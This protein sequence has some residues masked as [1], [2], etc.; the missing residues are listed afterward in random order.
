MRQIRLLH[1]FLTV[2]FWTFASRLLGFIRDVIIAAYLG[3]G[4]VAEAFLV[5]F[6]L[7]NMFRRIF[8]EGAFNT[9]FVPIFAKKI[10]AGEDAKGFA[11]DAFS[12]LASILI[13][14]TMIAHVAMPW[15]VLAM[16]SGFKGDERFDIA[17]TFGRICFPYILLIS[18]TAMLSGVLNATGR[19]AVASMAPAVLNIVFLIAF[20]LSIHYGW[21]MGLTQSWATPVGGVLQLLLVWH[22]ARKEGYSMRLSWPRLSPDMRRL[23]R[24]AMPAVFAGGIVQINLVVGRQV[25]S[26]YDGAIAW[27]SNADR[28]YQLPL[29]VV[30]AAV[31]VVLTAEL[32]RRLRAGD[33][34]G[35]RTAYNRAW[36]FSLFLTLPAAV[37]L[38]VIAGPI[39]SV[40]FERGQYTAADSAN[41]ALALIVYG[42]GLPAFTL[43][44][45]LQP[46]FYARE[47]TRRPFHYAI[48][49][50]VVNA[51]LAFGLSY[52]L[53][54]IAAAIGTTIA[55]WA[56]VFQLWWGSRSMGEAVRFDPRFLKNLVRILIAS[57]V[58]GLF[59]WG[60]AQ[61]LDGMLTQKGTRVLALFILCGA[62]MAVY[63]VTAIV[64]GVMKLADLLRM[65]RRQR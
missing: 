2:G 36:E 56:M 5:A 45:V 55:S 20:G 53:G 8:A 4:P 43:Q 1:G 29:G 40:I 59:L 10:E 48:V 63:F 62:G 22:A 44:K 35:S 11:Q 18:L 13:V 3:S 19:F 32:S 23:V 42:A 58:M 31:G 65:V 51:L 54:F 41:T 12:G 28:I 50:M 7:P 47:D 39:I 60:A 46:V 27:L 52:W 37:A 30:A 34:G 14:L 33:I 15:L 9:A 64:F 17:V 6:S 24:V 38:I 49:A 21:E 61:V 26:Y 57:A 25:A 16:A